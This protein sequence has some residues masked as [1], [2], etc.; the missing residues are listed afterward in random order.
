MFSPLNLSP[1]R[2]RHFY[3]RAMLAPLCLCLVAGF[4]LVRVWTCRQTPWKGGGFGMFS[5]VD[6]ESARFV[7]C[8]LVT[9]DGELPLAI[10]PAAAKQVA[11]LRAAPTQTK[12]DELAR[13]LARQSW[14]YREDRLAREAAAVR[15]S[16]GIGISSVVFKTNSGAQT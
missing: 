2:R 15:E 13:R 10:P 6:D 1:H 11:E 7:R 14:R 16:G 4:H 8:W 12:L 5:T 9:D 3:R